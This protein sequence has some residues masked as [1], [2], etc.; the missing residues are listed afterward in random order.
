[1]LPSGLVPAVILFGQGLRAPYFC[2]EAESGKTAF[3]DDDNDLAKQTR[4][5]LL[6][7]SDAADE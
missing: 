1:M 2:C 6:Y 7:T 3:A 4:I 5:C